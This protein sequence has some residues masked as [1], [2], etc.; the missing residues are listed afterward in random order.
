MTGFGFVKLSSG[1]QFDS[2]ACFKA[3]LHPAWNSGGVGCERPGKGFWR[4]DHSLVCSATM[5]KYHRLGILN[6]R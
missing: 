3:G 4:K 6:N 2:L 5:T 1:S